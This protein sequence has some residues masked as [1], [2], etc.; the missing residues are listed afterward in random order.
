MDEQIMSGPL[1]QEMRCDVKGCAAC[2]KDHPV[3]FER[4]D[5]V[6][7][8][9]YEG[10]CDDTG[11][12]LLMRF[13]GG[14]REIVADSESLDVNSPLGPTDI[15]D[16]VTTLREALSWALDI[17]DMYDTRLAGID[18]HERVYTATHLAGKAKA[19]A[20]LSR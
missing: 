19:R 17:M 18:G 12:L 14:V 15:V 8:W 5:E 7:D 9:P 11:Q 13:G 20:A 3:E 4:R 16:R 1:P 10:Y 6:Q 2:G